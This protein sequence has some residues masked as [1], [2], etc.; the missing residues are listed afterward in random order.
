M[1]RGLRPAQACLFSVGRTVFMKK[2]LVIEDETQLRSHLLTILTEEAFATIGAGDGVTGLQLAATH[3]PDLVLCDIDLPELNGHGVL[4]ALRAEPATAAI[5]LIFLTAQDSRAEMRA[6]MNLGADDYLTKPFLIDELL[7]AIAVRLLRREQCHLPNFR[8]VFTSPRP[9][10]AL[11]LTRREAEVLFWTAQS[12]TNPEISLLLTMSTATV[13]KHLQHIFAKI[14]VENRA[15]A[16]L[17][18]LET[19]GRANDLPRFRGRGG[20]IAADSRA[21]Q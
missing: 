18:A 19:L 6:G 12:K 4:R 17:M 8:A 11:G 1:R 5:P 16:M 15:A 10:E 21:R 2:I 3:R 7:T 20:V 9:L 14:G 13:K